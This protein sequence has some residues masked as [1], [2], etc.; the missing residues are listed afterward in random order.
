M[1]E[2][3]SGLT[4]RE[5]TMIAAHPTVTKVVPANVVVGG[6]PAKIINHSE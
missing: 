6:N 2:S 1:G 5:G 3:I 4:T